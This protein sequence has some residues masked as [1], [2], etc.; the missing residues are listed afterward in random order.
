MS[1]F[2]YPVISGPFA[3]GRFQYAH[4]RDSTMQ[5]VRPLQVPWNLV[6]I[7]VRFADIMVFIGFSWDLI[8]RR[9]SLT[10]KKRLKFLG[11]VMAM[12]TCIEDGTA[13]SLLGIQKIHGSLVHICFVYVEGSSH[14]PVISNFMAHFKGNEFLRRHGSRSLTKTLF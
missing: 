6:K 7:G 10:E 13:L 5:L 9:V 1:N 12:L 11:R 3:E 8:H 2:R 4:D 14:L